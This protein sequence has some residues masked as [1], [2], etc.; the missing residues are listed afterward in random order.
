MDTTSVILRNGWNEPTTYSNISTVTLPG[1]DGEPKVFTYGTGSGGKSIQ[2]DWN[3]NDDSQLD[4]IKN[5]PF[6]TEGDI[7]PAQEIN[8]IESPNGGTRSYISELETINFIAEAVNCEEYTVIW[9][10][11]P[12][13][14]CRCRD[15]EVMHRTNGKSFVIPKVI[16]N[17]SLFAPSGGYIY[18]P[19]PSTNYPFVFSLETQ[20][21]ETLLPLLTNENEP[22]Y[23]NCIA[24]SDKTKTSHTI[25]VYATEKIHQIDPK[26]IP[27]YE[28]DN[29]LNKPDIVQ[30]NWT[31]TS[32][33]DPS[34]IRNKPTGLIDVKGT[35]N[36]NTVPVFQN[37]QWLAKAVP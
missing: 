34:F 21:D 8:F 29:I 18:N 20:F 35:I 25:Q 30:A 32:S 9:D 26:Y 22:I 3:Q 10:D 33:D 24:T 5:R 28:W 2:S 7:I 14:N 13:E 4:Y 27:P 1:A 31:E 11:T 17:I 16:G 23:Y 6:F 37:S 12:Y 36:N 19:S 15:I